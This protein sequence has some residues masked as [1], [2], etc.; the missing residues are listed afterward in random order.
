[1]TFPKRLRFRLLLYAVIAV[2][3]EFIVY[4]LYLSTGD[5]LWFF[6]LENL[7]VLLFPRIFSAGNWVTLGVLGMFLFVTLIGEVIYRMAQALTQ[8]VA[9][10]EVSRVNRRKWIAVLAIGLVVGL[11]LGIAIGALVIG[12]REL[13]CIINP[14]QV[15][16][17]VSGNQYG[18]IQFVN[19]HEAESTRYK[20]V[21]PITGGSYSIVLSSGQSYH[22]YIGT[23]QTSPSGSFSL[24]VP[25]NATSLTANFPP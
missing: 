24:Y 19:D 20:H 22:V 6:V 3:V 11:G 21:V 23:G 16:G 12:P 10:P 18:S 14:V 4:G 5:G 15:S 13:L 2:A 8:P 9:V 7:N 1:V 17:T 25:A